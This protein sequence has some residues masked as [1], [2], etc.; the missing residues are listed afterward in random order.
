M[1][2]KSTNEEFT[3]G[4]IRLYAERVREGETARGGWMSVKEFVLSR[5][6]QRALSRHSQSMRFH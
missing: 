4:A 5:E 1:I 3:L 2:K 6:K